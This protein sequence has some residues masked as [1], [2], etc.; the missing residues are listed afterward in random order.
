ML[1][2][3]LRSL[4][5]TAAAVALAASLLLPVTG[6]DAREAKLG[7][8]AP[9]GDPRHEA[10][11][12]FADIVEEQTEG[13]IT[14]VIFPDSTLGSERE[15]FEQV[16][17]GV[18]ELALV[19]AIVGNFYPAWA[20]VDMP[21]LWKSQEHLMEFMNSP[22]AREWSDDMGEQ[23]GVE[24]LAF[25]D[26]NPRILSTRDRPVHSIDDLQGM[27][28]R[29]PDIATFMDTWRAFG[30]E[31]TPMPAAD[32]Y[33]ALRLGTIDAMENPVEVMYHWNIHEVADYLSL[34]EH[35]RSG[36]FFIASQQFMDSLTEEQRE[37][38]RAAALEAQALL[39][40]RNRDGAESLLDDLR[41]EGMEI[42]EDP[43]ISGFL[44]ASEQVH[45]QYM[46]RFGREAYEEAV[47]LGEKY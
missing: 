5:G 29:V 21:F 26:R 27:K 4:I 43:D 39:A 37:I 11:T 23:L 1:Q 33:M 36:F 9:T 19:S 40:Q 15:M 12:L 18:T 47:A 16:Q 30:V 20:I 14:V 6:A 2:L 42:I 35:M 25:L 28:V 3:R 44:A 8:L 7:H 38:V 46:D 10:L 45:E 34:T 31:P 22:R 17:A 24:M 32:F 13:E 41:A